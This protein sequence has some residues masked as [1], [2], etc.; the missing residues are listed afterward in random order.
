MSRPC[1][2]GGSGSCMV[3]E[4]GASLP[5]MSPGSSGSPSEPSESIWSKGGRSEQPHTALRAAGRIAAA[6]RSRAA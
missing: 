4:K 2:L 1:V 6:V 5:P 3:S